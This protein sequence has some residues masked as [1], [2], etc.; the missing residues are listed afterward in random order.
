VA[1]RGTPAT[2]VLDAAGVTFT[3]ISYSRDLTDTSYGLAAATALDIDPAAIFKTLVAA[4][5]SALCVAVVPVTGTLDLKALAAARGGKR[6]GL[7]QAAL[8]ERSSGYVVGG[9]SPLGQR[10]R[11]PTVVDASGLGLPVM[12]VSAGRRGLEIGLAPGD[13]I[14]L[15]GATVAAISAR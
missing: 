15:T 4:V 5:D 10:R 14:A 2:A 9:I 8:A 11:L 12:Y 7:A 1:G 6:A 3:L 13:L